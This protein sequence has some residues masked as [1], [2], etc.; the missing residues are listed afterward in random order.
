LAAFLNAR[1]GARRSEVSL[2]ISRDGELLRV[3]LLRDGAELTVRWVSLIDGVVTDDARLSLWLALNAAFERDDAR[4]AT[5]P[6]TREAVTVLKPPPPQRL[7]HGKAASMTSRANSPMPLELAFG[8]LAA[9]A[10][11]GFDSLGAYLGVAG[12][13]GALLKPVG[14]LGYQWSRVDEELSLHSVMLRGHLDASSFA[15]LSVGASAQ[16]A[17]EVASAAERS[18]ASLGV[19]LGPSVSLSLGALRLRLM[20]AAQVLRQRYVS[21][22]SERTEP[23]WSLN[24][25]LGAA[26]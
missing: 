10:P 16:L 11:R 19:G 14:E 4:R 3:R 8:A 23:W 26:L 12:T 1:L 25:A 2:E 17:F 9:L 7:A 22:A 6:G 24:L 18:Q 5:R 20:G 13:E 21:S 15:S